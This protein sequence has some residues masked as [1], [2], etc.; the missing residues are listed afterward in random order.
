M[1][2]ESNNLTKLFIACWNDDALKQRFLS[3]P[4]AVLAEHGLDAPEGMNV[5]VVENTDNTVHDTLPIGPE[6]HHE[7]SD[8]EL[9]NAAGDLL[10]GWGWAGC[11]YNNCPDP[12]YT[13]GAQTQ[14]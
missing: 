4:S 1:T 13:C 12:T 2:D 5:I 6:N 9:T 11:T 8:E 14:N 3:D 7:L 10:T